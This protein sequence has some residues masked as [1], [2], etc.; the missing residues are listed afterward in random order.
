MNQDRGMGSAASGSVKLVDLKV[1]NAPVLSLFQATLALVMPS[2]Q[3]QLHPK[4]TGFIKI[5]E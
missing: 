3:K 4:S 5:A 1:A 2:S